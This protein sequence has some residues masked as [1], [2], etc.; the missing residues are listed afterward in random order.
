MM[1]QK[2]KFWLWKTDKM[3]EEEVKQYL[4]L[5]MYTMYKLIKFT[6]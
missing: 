4:G 1:Q 6:K 2:S 5:L 3:F